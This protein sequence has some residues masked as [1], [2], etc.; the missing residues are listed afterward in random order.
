MEKKNTQTRTRKEK[1]RKQ[2]G[3]REG[4]EGVDLRTLALGELDGELAAL[5]L[6]AVELVDGIVGVAGLL[7]LEKRKIALDIAPLDVPDLLKVPA[8]VLLPDTPAKT[9]VGGNEEYPWEQEILQLRKRER[10]QKRKRLRSKIPLYGLKSG[11]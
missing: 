1:I 10:A 4:D 6:A 2:E 3:T 11:F 5:E 7:E 9:K 8:D